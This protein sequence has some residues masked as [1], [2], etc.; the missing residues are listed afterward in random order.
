MRWATSEAT[1]SCSY[2]YILRK[3][4][5]SASEG[6]AGETKKGAGM[7]RGPGHWPQLWIVV[8]R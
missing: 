8:K 4:R 6:R 2:L 1:D 7:H 3:N 5:I